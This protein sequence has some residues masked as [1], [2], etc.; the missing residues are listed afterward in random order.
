VQCYNCCIGNDVNCFEEDEDIFS[1]LKFLEGLQN[2]TFPHS[3]MA[4]KKN[5]KICV[6]RG[7]YKES[8]LLI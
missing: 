4:R 5:D 6:M 7:M 1:I 8:M 2:E 3:P